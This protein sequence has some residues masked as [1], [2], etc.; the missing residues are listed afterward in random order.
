MKDCAAAC[1]DPQIPAAAVSVRRLILR[2]ATL[3]FIIALSLAGASVA[4]AHVPD[5]PIGSIRV[6]LAGHQQG[7]T[8]TNRNPPEMIR[9]F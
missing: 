8:G 5:S 7:G 1:D 4:D 2:P 3:S 9:L 6:V